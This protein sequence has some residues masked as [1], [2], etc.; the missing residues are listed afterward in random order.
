[1]KPIENTNPASPVRYAIPY[2]FWDRLVIEYIEKINPEKRYRTFPE[3]VFAWKNPWA[4]RIKQNKIAQKIGLLIIFFSCSIKKHILSHFILCE[5]GQLFRQRKNPRFAWVVYEH[6]RQLPLMG[7][8]SIIRRGDCWV[9]E[10]YKKLSSL[11]CK[12]VSNTFI[13]VRLIQVECREYI[14]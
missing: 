4:K 5:V 14:R 11:W 7:N 13:R 2:F 10:V 9:Y 1:M 12:T 8:P 6:R 3:I